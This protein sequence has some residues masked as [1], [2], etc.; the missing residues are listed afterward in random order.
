MSIPERS[1]QQHKYTAVLHVL[2]A[3][4]FLAAAFNYCAPVSPVIAQGAA[5]VPGELIVGFG[6]EVESGSFLLNNEKIEFVDTPQPL[7]ESLNAYLVRVPAGEEIN[8]RSQLLQLDE[9]HFVDLNYYIT[10]LE[11]PT[12][13]IP[14]DPNW[15]YQY[16]PPAVR[17]DYAWNVTTGSSGVIIAIVD[18]GINRSHPEFSGRLIQGYDFVQGDSI[19]EDE[20]GHGTHVAGIAAATGNNARG[21]AGVDWH[22]KIMAVR[23]LDKN[24]SGT[25]ANTAA[26]IIWAADHGADVINLSLSG[27]SFPSPTIL[28]DATYYA[29]KKGAVVVAAA[30]NYNSTPVT[31]PARY[32]W[33]IAVGMTDV[34]NTRRS[35]SNYGSELDLM[36][37]GY[38]ILSTMPGGYGYKSGTSM[39]TPFVSG[40]AA[41]LLTDTKFDSTLKIYEALTQT[42]LDLGTVG[43][44]DYYGYGL[45]QLDSA[46]AYNPTT[47]P[48]EEP[49]ADVVYELRES[50]RCSNITFNW[51]D[52]PRTTENFVGIFGNNSIRTVDLPFVFRFGGEDYSRIR[53]S[54]NGFISFDMT[55]SIYDSERVNGPLPGIGKPQE[56]LAPF[57]DDL[58]PSANAAAGIYHMTVGSAP[59]RRYIIE[60]YRMPLQQSQSSYVTFQITMFEESGEID[61]QYLDHSG[62]L[63]SGSSASIGLEYGSGQ[64]GVQVGFNELGVVSRKLALKF[65]PVEEGIPADVPDCVQVTALPPDTSTTVE[66]AEEETGNRTLE[67]M[68]FRVFLPEGVPPPG[69]T[70]QLK[71]FLGFTTAYNGMIDLHQYAQLIT[72]PAQMGWL[73]PKPRLC[74]YYD[75]GDMLAAGGHAE[76]LV[77][78]VFDHSAG[79]WS[80]LATF[81]DKDAGTVCAYI[82]YYSVYGV[83][84]RDVPEKLPVTGASKGN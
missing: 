81:L 21:V 52:V 67:S 36:A 48:P 5:Y 8:Y 22:A 82:P 49:E 11:S 6:G 23:V 43:R 31:Y 2:V 55:T 57:W 56:V 76:N 68:P 10:A 29:Y 9:V 70:L 19:P 27:P 30:G 33:V 66:K 18:T 35:E 80:P 1:T 4:L 39:S 47:I 7:V 20:N 58:N 62:T 72:I 15:F 38:G 3:C 13:I 44:D 69:T 14:D 78:G 24:G 59:A 84:G 16:G 61:F 32:P 79:S 65:F 74:Y 53:V 12:P 60:W 41:L 71:T 73:D 50:S 83:F 34:S 77:L 63:S 37:P 46:L 25:L 40:A 45:L 54:D 42:A 75:N 28:E 64:F 51:V 26:G 17:A